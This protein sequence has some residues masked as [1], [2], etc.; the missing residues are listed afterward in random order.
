[1]NSPLG[2]EKKFQEIFLSG[3]V[4]E[5]LPDISFILTYFWVMILTSLPGLAIIITV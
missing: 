2:L 1:M 3:R 4:T 5:G